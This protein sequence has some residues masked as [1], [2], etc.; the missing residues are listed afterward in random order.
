M[1]ILDLLPHEFPSAR[2]MTYG[3]DT[4]LHGNNSTQSFFSLGDELRGKLEDLIGDSRGIEA[5][6]AAGSASESNGN[7]IKP[8]IFIAHSLGGL[9]VREVCKSL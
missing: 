3:F 6:E 4:K 9:I 1:W 7:H 2:I 5:H 8:L